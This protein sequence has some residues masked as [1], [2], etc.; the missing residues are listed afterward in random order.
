M[1]FPLRTDRTR[2]RLHAGI[3]VVR[4]HGIQTPVQ[5]RKQSRGQPTRKWRLRSSPTLQRR[6]SREKQVLKLKIVEAIHKDQ[7]EGECKLQKESLGSRTVLVTRSHLNGE[8]NSLGRPRKANDTGDGCMRH[9]WR[10]ISPRRDFSRHSIFPP[11]SCRSRGHPS[12]N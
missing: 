9:L 10:T 12:R 6:K 8:H 1:R 5:P 4:A 11:R 7:P 3:R 2:M